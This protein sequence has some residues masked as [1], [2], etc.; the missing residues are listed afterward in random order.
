MTELPSG[1]VTFV[2][3]DIEGS[4]AL[5]E[6]HPD[7][8]G[9]TVARHD[10]LLAAEIERRD[11]MVIHN[12]GEGDSFFAV[13]RRAIDAVTAARDIQRALRA[14]AWPTKEPLRVRIGVHTGEAEL[15]N[16]DYFGS[17]V[18]R[19]ARIRAIAHGGQTLVSSTTYNLI[20]DEPPEKVDLLDLGEYQLKDLLQPERVYQ[21]AES[22][23]PT[24]FPPIRALP[25]RPNNLPVPTT[26]LIGRE[27]EV[28]QISNQ[29][30]GDT[31]LL[32]L[33]GAGGIGK[34]RIAVE[35]A[36]RLA[37]QGLMAVAF[38]ELAPIADPALVSHAI[39]AA[40]GVLQHLDH[41]LLET[42]VEWIRSAR[43]LLVLDN[44]E[45]LTAGCGPVAKTLIAAC[46]E[47]RILATSQAPLGVS[48]EAI[49]PAPLL[50]VD[51]DDAL[52]SA[53]P[54]Y[55]EAVQLFVERARLKVPGFALTAENRRTVAAICRHLDG[56]PLAIELAAARI[57]L[58]PPAAILSRLNRRLA[59]LVGGPQDLPTRQQT[60]RATITW[61][62]DLLNERERTLFRQLGI[63]VG[64]FSLEAAEAI[65]ASADPAPASS[66]LDVLDSL[67]AK[68]LL[69]HA[70]TADEPRFTILQTV[71]EY[72]REQLIASTQMQSVRDRCVRFFVAL[73]E[74]AAQ[75]FLGRRQLEWLERVDAELDQLRA[76]FGWVRNGE[77]ATEVGM[78]LVGALI[79]YWE[80][81]G[82]TVEGNDWLI[83]M[84]A[85]PA[86]SARTLEAARV[87]YAA[88]IFATIRDSPDQG[89]LAE[90]SAL[91]F[92]EVGHLDES[93]RS[94]AQQ[95]VAEVRLGHLAEARALLEQ[96]LRIAK[97]HDDTWCLAF[98]LGQL[99][100][101]A[102]RDANYSVAHRF[103]SDAAAAARAVG[104][105][106]TLGLALAGLGQVARAQQNYEE[107]AR[108]FHETL[109]V[110]AEIK[111]QWVMPRA[112]GALAGAAVLARD[113]E[114]AA[115]LF[116]IAA[117]MRTASGIS[118]A[119]ESYRVNYADD[120]QEARG[121]LGET[122]FQTKW[123][124]GQ[125]LSLEL[126][127]AYALT[128]SIEVADVAVPQPVSV[129]SKEQ[130]AD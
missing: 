46:P 19:C 113:Y 21:V 122:L 98:A 121:A 117:E 10:E 81:R 79:R 104:D 110:A 100:A 59:L 30:L 17:A 44:C 37:D 16:N 8:M 52:Q 72:A 96:S 84:L 77:V 11:G 13:F 2:L 20:R 61:S 36:R 112:I 90:K 105:R 76:V 32:T 119:S 87:L 124:Q 22:E 83:A 107:S 63:F 69:Q 66:L 41:P 78:R 125:D 60:I 99:G 93:G 6:R 103:R 56:L 24:A 31:R 43:L 18:N 54:R 82:L 53:S 126:S 35:V 88:S 57:Q 45:H 27:R 23:L 109:E 86:A 39:G 50:T 95:A 7:A 12:R 40:L 55:S 114:R 106:H 91:L 15:R 120:Q 97:E 49:W 129:S 115:V 1:K 73:A 128:G 28:T 94:L 111:D 3:T 118:E 80:Y 51:G 75:G 47:L 34:T 127:I 58:L 130:G 71:R 74:E 33:S 25:T 65:C 29:L 101:V 9:Q 5:W 70:N 102:Y 92:K 48:G 68:N 26:T 67:L 116:G 64:S 89:P 108:L 38:V 123:L 14:E 42:I 62:Y 85:T 4:T